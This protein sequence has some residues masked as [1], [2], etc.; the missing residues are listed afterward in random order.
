ME[1]IATN[2]VTKKTFSGVAKDKDSFVLMLVKK[3]P[4]ISGWYPDEIKECVEQDL[5]EEV[6]P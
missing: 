6:K 4:H 2:P 1:F 5:I 3:A